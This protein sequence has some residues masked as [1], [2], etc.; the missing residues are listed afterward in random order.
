MLRSCPRRFAIAG[1]SRAAIFR[2]R[3]NCEY[4]NS[5]RRLIWLQPLLLMSDPSRFARELSEPPANGC[6]AMG[7]A[8]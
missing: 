2:L 5:F 1:Q 6:L 7:M 4:C 3:G 8:D